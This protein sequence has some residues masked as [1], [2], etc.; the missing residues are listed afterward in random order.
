MSGSAA[1]EVRVA[2][3]SARC[4]GGSYTPMMSSHARRRVAE[5]FVYGE[6]TT[7]AQNDIKQATELTNWSPS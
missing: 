4:T 6:V 3:P 5:E 1:R 2:Q 7:G